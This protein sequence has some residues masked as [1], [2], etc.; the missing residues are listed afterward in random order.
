MSLLTEPIWR[1]GDIV[2][3]V[4]QVYGPPAYPQITNRVGQTGVIEEI[5]THTPITNSLL[6]GVILKIRFPDG[7]IVPYTDDEVMTMAGM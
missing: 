6:D 3:V 7:E 2:R 1:I 4:N 5:I